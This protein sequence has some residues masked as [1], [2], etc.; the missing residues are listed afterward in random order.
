[1][2]VGESAGEFVVTVGSQVIKSSKD[3][4][5]CDTVANATKI[6]LMN[7]GCDITDKEH[8][9]KVGQVFVKEGEREGYIKY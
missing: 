7:R 1:M 2:A 8:L 5:I 4:G 9:V 3:R 6:D